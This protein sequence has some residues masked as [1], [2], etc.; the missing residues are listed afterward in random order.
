VQGVE[1]ELDEHK[2]ITTMF[3]QA[4]EYNVQM[5]NIL[6]KL[7]DLEI[8]NKKIIRKKDGYV[9]NLQEALEK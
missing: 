3:K 1:A 2:R 6:F 9:Q 8:K 5:I 7:F 4:A